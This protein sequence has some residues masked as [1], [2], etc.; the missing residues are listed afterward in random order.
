MTVNLRALASW[1]YWQVSW[2]ISPAPTTSVCLLEKSS[3]IALGHIHRHGGDG[4]LALADLGFVA[5]ALA[6]L[7][8][9]VEEAVEQP[10]GGALLGG[11]GVGLLDLV[12]DL[13]FAQH[14]R[15]QPAGHAEEVADRL[16]VAELVEVRAEGLHGQVAGL[17]D[18]A[19]H[20]G[21][22]WGARSS[23]ATSIS[24]RLQVER[25]AASELGNWLRKRIR[26][27]A[28]PSRLKANCSRISTGAVR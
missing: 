17:G 3:K 28:T 5:D 4:G 20:V 6:D 11:L 19:D 9:V 21:R 23:L 24:T 2:A 27:V 15:I 18:E 16:L 1:R 13:V 26:A 10:A 25:M 8:G 7:K 14:H 22:G 12:D